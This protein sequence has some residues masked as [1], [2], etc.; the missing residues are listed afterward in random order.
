MLN[1]QNILPLSKFA[2]APLSKRTRTSSTLETLAAYIRGV[3][4]YRKLE[5][6]LMPV[7]IKTSF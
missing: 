3:H 4:P 5:S 7:K 6:T 2:L 1:T